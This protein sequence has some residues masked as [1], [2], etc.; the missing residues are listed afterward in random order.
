MTAFGNFEA[1]CDAIGIDP[2]NRKLMFLGAGNMAMALV[3]GC[4]RSGG[5]FEFYDSFFVK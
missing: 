4:L 5:F 1:L 3:E 2:P